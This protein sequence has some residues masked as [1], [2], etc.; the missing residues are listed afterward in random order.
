MV[1]RIL[2]RVI[3]YNSLIF[4]HFFNELIINATSIFTT[5]NISDAVQQ[6][7]SEL[8]HIWSG[9]SPR[10][11]EKQNAANLIE[12]MVIYELVHYHLVVLQPF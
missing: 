11:A 1:S 2:N 3:W 12:R 4:A 6:G 5:K 9:Q 8:T 7:D 10:L